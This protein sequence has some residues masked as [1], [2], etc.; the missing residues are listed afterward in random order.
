VAILHDPGDAVANSG[1]AQWA[2]SLLRK[3]LEAANL[4]VRM[5]AARPGDFTITISSGGDLA[6]SPKSG[7]LA[8]SSRD[9]EVLVHSLTDLA[10]QVAYAQNPIQTLGSASEKAVSSPNRIRSIMRMFVSDVE[11]KAWFQSKDFWPPYL[12]MLATHRFNRF[13]LSFGLGYDA[14]SRLRDTYLY[15]AYPFLMDV[16]GYKVKAVGLPDKERDLNLQMVRYISDECAARGMQFQMGLWTHAFKWI[17]SPQANYVINGL[18]DELQGPYSRDAI[19]RLLMEC[20]NITGV[21][22][23]VHGESGVPEGSYDFWKMLFGGIVATGRKIEIDMHAKGMDQQMRDVALATGLPVK[24]SPKFWAEHMGLPYMQASIRQQEMPPAVART[25]M[26]SLSSGSRSFLRYSFGDLL[27][28]DRKYGVLHR[29]WPGTQRLLLWGDPGFAAE[30]GKLFSFLD[31]DGV[32]YFD[33]LSFKGRKGSGLPGDRGG[34]SDASLRTEGSWPKYE[35]T[36]RLLGRMAQ[37][38]DCDPDVIRRQLNKSLGDGNTIAYALAYASRILPLITSAHDPSAANSN[39]WPEMYLNMSMADAAAGGP[40]TDT[41]RPHVFGTVSPLDPQIFATIEESSHAI[42]QGESLAKV[43]AQEVARELERH[44]ALAINMLAPSNKPPDISDPAVRRAMIDIKIAA[45][46]GEFFSHKIRAGLLWTMFNATGDEAV[47]AACVAEYKNARDAWAKLSDDASVYA[48][49]LTFGP[50]AQL[51]G[52]WKDRLPAIDEDIAAVMGHVAAAKG[53]NP[54]DL[55]LREITQP[56]Q[57]PEINVGP[58]V[59]GTFAP[60]Q[61]IRLTIKS[62]DGTLASAKLW[63]RHVNQA[64]TFQSL[65]ATQT[66][67]QFQAVIPA[68]YAETPFAIQYYWELR[69]KGGQVRQ[70]PGFQPGFSGVPYYVMKRA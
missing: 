22:L 15:F 28:S 14:A 19:H 43:T 54:T 58:S 33:P 53:A 5:D 60:A 25:G 37:N 23:R 2:I 41:P 10:D 67:D 68:A 8:V 48:S 66:A 57:R 52:H 24:V 17:D 20:P 56:R 13:N 11:D 70:Y 47:R 21:T 40:Y 65:E 61:P 55:M 59:P 64:E 62:T 45:G 42:L 39:Y 32:E 36:Y 50:E 27:K 30:Y 69:H 44:S 49:D 34:Y 38:P 6:V 18:T 26:Y 35:Y 31:T 16:A 63:Y 1:P 46:I 9:A 12:D 3:R 29:V 51:R 7:G 4:N